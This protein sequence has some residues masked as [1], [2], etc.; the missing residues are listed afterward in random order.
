MSKY[1]DEHQRDELVNAFIK[2][3]NKE[4]LLLR[5]AK[6]FATENHSHGK[7]TESY[8]DTYLGACRNL[9]ASQNGECHLA[10]AKWRGVAPNPNKLGRS[11][12]FIVELMD[13]VDYV[14]SKQHKLQLAEVLNNRGGKNFLK[15][16]YDKISKG[17]SLEIQADREKELEILRTRENEVANMLS[18]ITNFSVLKG[19]DS[20][21]S[22]K[23]VLWLKIAY[24]NHIERQIDEATGT[25][26]TA[27]KDIYNRIDIIKD[28]N[29]LRQ[30]IERNSYADRLVSHY[31]MNENF[32]KLEDEHLRLCIGLAY[33][34]IWDY[35]KEAKLETC[36]FT[37][38]SIYFGDEEVVFR[39]EDAY[40]EDYHKVYSHKQ[41]NI[42]KLLRMAEIA[43]IDFEKTVKQI[44]KKIEGRKIS[45]LWNTFFTNSITIDE[46]F[47]K[48]HSET[49]RN[50]DME[51]F[52]E[53]KQ[54]YKAF[55]NL[56]ASLN[57]QSDIVKA[58]THKTYR[59]RKKK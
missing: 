37:H 42:K 41:K 10:W 45:Y 6:K 4:S 52:E 44:E 57:F 22:W 15:A 31:Y 35:R 14:G 53:D 34:D 40:V 48:A 51:T 24:I 19:Y 47:I 11:F 58:I 26:K 30:H 13:E 5:K 25:V 21:H 18:P 54:G 23:R 28:L 39:K 59:E 12:D 8:I 36:V 17:T 46:D 29:R 55:E 7:P 20:F 9:V 38:N 2:A 33:S 43:D 27:L 16:V 50:E 56:Y 3:K 32:T 49:M 1:L